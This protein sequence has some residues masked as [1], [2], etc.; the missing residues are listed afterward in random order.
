L[1]AD[2]QSAN[3]LTKAEAKSKGRSTQWWLNNFLWLK[4]W[5][6]WTESHQ[7]STMCTEM[8]ADYF[9]EIKISIFQSVWNANVTNNDHH[10]IAGESWQKL[11]VL[12]AYTR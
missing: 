6:H 12:T 7:I 1:K 3:P 11:L 2:L 10:Q 4:L 8:I 5:G 9:A